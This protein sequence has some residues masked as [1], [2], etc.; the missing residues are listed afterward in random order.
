[1]H[2]GAVPV[3]RKEAPSVPTEVCQGRIWE[4]VDFVIRA[5]SCRGFQTF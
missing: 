2:V 3:S 5:K 4:G 1:V